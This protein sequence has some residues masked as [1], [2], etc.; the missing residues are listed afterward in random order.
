VAAFN[1]DPLVYHG[2]VK[3]RILHYILMESRELSAQVRELVLPLLILHGAEDK[4]CDPAGSQLLY[5]T[6]ASKD[7]TLKFYPGLRHE[8]HNEPEKSDVL[9]DVLSWLDAH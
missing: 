3:T 6:A 5:D 8:I 2:G 4:L 7:K 9:A 1:S